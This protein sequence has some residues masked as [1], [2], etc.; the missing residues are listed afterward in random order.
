M[1][2]PQGLLEWKCFFSQCTVASS[3]NTTSRFHPA[4]VAVFQLCQLCLRGPV[5]YPLSLHKLYF[6]MLHLAPS[7]PQLS[8]LCY[9]IKPLLL[10]PPDCYLLLKNLPVYVS[11]SMSFPH[12][13]LYLISSLQFSSLTSAWNFCFVLLLHILLP[14]FPTPTGSEQIRSRCLHLSVWHQKWDKRESKNRVSLSLT[15]SVWSHKHTLC[16]SGFLYACAWW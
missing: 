10:F 6:S 3:K 13:Q 7:N 15:H 1:F 14:P 12:C 5:H 2:H 8:L 16:P 4:S 11:N 9:L